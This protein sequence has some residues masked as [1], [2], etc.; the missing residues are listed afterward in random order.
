MFF[1][2]DKDNRLK[3]IIGIHN[4]LLGAVFGGRQI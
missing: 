2:I 4:R 1:C 3:V